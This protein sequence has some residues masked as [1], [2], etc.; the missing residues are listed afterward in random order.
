MTD[1]TNRSP[2]ELF[3]NLFHNVH[4]V[5]QSA[6]NIALAGADQVR[7]GVFPHGTG[8]RG[9]YGFTVRADLGRPN[10]R[11]EPFG[12]VRPDASGQPVVQDYMEPRTEVTE[13]TEQ[14][15]IVSEVPGVA[16]EDIKLE[17]NGPTIAFSAERGGRK[18]RKEV[19]LPANADTNQVL[20]A[21]HDGLLEIRIKK[22]FT[23]V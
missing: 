1:T 12:N 6:G 7:K 18:Y 3:K 19:V 22:M 14:Y 13:E 10:F 11:I 8:L 23:C 2:E 9:I 4:G 5:L 21:C 20:H 17:V 15:L 16:P